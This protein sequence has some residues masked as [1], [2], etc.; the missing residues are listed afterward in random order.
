MVSKT[1]VRR[2]RVVVEVIEANGSSSL[3]RGRQVMVASISDVQAGQL[4]LQT[5]KSFAW[6]VRKLGIVR[7][8]ERA[9]EIEL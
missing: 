6:H 9:T 7:V 8:D 2:V 1:A 3:R 4:A 5:A